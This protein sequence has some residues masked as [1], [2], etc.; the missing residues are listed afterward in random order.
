MKADCGA[1]QE[2]DKG[3]KISG[4][5]GEPLKGFCVVLNFVGFFRWFQLS[6][7]QQSV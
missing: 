7:E 1:P 4:V 2:D 3:I 5:N 6:L